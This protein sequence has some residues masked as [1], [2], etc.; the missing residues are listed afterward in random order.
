MAGTL[1]ELKMALIQIKGKLIQHPVFSRGAGLPVDDPGSTTEIEELNRLGVRLSIIV[2]ELR[3]KSASLTGREAGLWGMKPDQRY[4][5]KASIRG[6]QA[7]LQE[8]LRLAAEIQKLLDDLIRKNGLLEEG[9]IAKGVSEFLE[10][11]YHDAHHHTEVHSNPSQLSY[12]PAPAAGHFAGSLEGLTIWIFVAL[13]ALH[14]RAQRKQ[15]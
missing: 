14:N 3:N 8:V 11:V 1:G 5:A 6:Q 4:L 10:H 2:R 12:I 15:K 7:E 13:R 9:E